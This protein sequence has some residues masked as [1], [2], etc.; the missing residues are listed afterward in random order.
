MDSNDKKAVETLC[1]AIVQTVKD[2][3]QNKDIIATVLKNP[4][5][6]AY[7]DFQIDGKEQKVPNGIGITFKAGDT[8]LIHCINGDYSNK[9]IIAKI[10]GAIKTT[11]KDEHAVSGEALILK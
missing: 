8:A 10:N 7:C 9:V 1:K 3:S 2:S 11:D 5:D 6:L 4:T